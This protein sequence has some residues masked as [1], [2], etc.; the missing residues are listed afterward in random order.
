MSK[1]DDGPVRQGYKALEDL[2]I[3]NL[4]RL[5]RDPVLLGPASRFLGLLGGVRRTC[6]DLGE[7]WLGCWGLPTRSGQ[8]ETLALLQA[9]EERLL[10][11]E[12]ELATARTMGTGG[13]GGARTSGDAAAR[14]GDPGT[15]GAA[16][17][18][19]A[20]AAAEEVGA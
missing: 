2:W 20:A 13:T 4:Q 14:A 19:R 9:L 18:G 11:L 7:A 5:V 16:T 8:R 17:A 15:A 12:D 10:Q 6:Q 1:A 3:G